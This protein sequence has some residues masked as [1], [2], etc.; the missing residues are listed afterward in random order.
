MNVISALKHFLT[1]MGGEDLV[2]GSEIELYT[3]V[4]YYYDEDT[5]A[6]ATRPELRLT[7]YAGQILKRNDRSTAEWQPLLNSYRALKRM[8][9]PWTARS[10][11]PFVY[12]KG[13]VIARPGPESYKI[14]V[15]VYDTHECTLVSE[16]EVQITD[17]EAKDNVQRADSMERE[18]DRIRT[19]TTRVEKK[20]NCSP[21]L[22]E[23]ESELALLEETP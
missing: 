19:A 5:K 16:V 22:P 10:E 9:G 20:W 4:D 2:L 3:S 15:V 8:S 6:F 1:E 13:E 12:L 21:A 23:S 18:A 11:P 14:R 7:I 17:K